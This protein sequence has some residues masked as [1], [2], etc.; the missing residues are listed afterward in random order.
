MSQL[1]MPSSP[2]DDSR[3][4][5]HMEFLD[6]IAQNEAE[7]LQVSRMDHF[8]E[9]QPQTPTF[10]FAAATGQV[11]H[12]ADVLASISAIGRNALMV[13]SRHGL[14]FFS[15]YNHILNAHVS[16]DASL[17]STFEY[18]WTSNPQESEESLPKNVQ[19]GID[20]HMLNDAFAAAAATVMPRSKNGG[21]NASSAPSDTV[22]CYIK[23]R[24][25]GY[26]LV[27]EF[28]D[29]LMSEQIE[30]STFH[31]DMDFPYANDNPES[32]GQ[33]PDD[34]GALAIDHSALRF[35]V[36]LQSD[37]LANLLQD[38]QNL[39]TEDLYMFVS[40]KMLVGGGSHSANASQ[41]SINFIS[42][43]A[44]GYSKL[45][46]P[47]ARTMLQ[48][49]EVYKE[50]SMEPIPTT[51]SVLCTIAFSPF[52]KV[53]RAVKL[54]TKCKIMKDFNGVFSIQLLCKNTAA[55]SY[56]GTLIAFNMLER[57]DLGVTGQDIGLDVASLFD[58]QVY[59][60]VMEYDHSKQ[61]TSYSETR[62]ETFTHED[63]GIS[64]AEPFSY[65]AFQRRPN[66]VDDASKRRRVETG[67]SLGTSAP[68]DDVP[69][70]L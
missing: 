5:D 21:N 48:K 51:D 57:S 40:N 34:V 53:L 19:V 68:V 7:N 24:G 30:F 14:S 49:L 2:A 13:I 32:Q 46:Y 36:I 64:A 66:N 12:L 23:Y 54:S 67:E 29:R 69:L 22:L 20:V 41:N 62:T 47:N 26:P 27:V 65:A 10:S 63:N 37:I 59:Q 60:Q 56:P 55:K 44:I 17:F 38:L 11:S 6:S 16:I 3:H 52:I 42:K 25:E 39:N 45:I 15:E 61:N 18:H 8:S 58:D 4:M 1:F 9:Q 33:N 70:F 35:E 31:L 50:G 28:E 43:G